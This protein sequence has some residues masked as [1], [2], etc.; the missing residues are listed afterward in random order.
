MSAPVPS[1][2]APGAEGAV[3]STVWPSELTG[4]DC[5]PAPFSALTVK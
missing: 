5:S 1:F 4:V 3:L 2:T